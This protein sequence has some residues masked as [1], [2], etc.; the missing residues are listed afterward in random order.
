MRTLRNNSEC[1]FEDLIIGSTQLN[2]KYVSRWFDKSFSLIVTKDGHAGL[3]FEHSWGDG[4]AVIRYFNEIH[5]DVTERPLVHP[6]TMR[7]GEATVRKLG[8]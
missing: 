1:S 4:V 7:T 6:N 8:I 2:V 5:T 3:N